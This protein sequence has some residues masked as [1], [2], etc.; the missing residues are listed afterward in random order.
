MEF[1]YYHFG[2]VGS[3]M[4]IIRPLLPKVEAN[5][6][7]DGRGVIVTA[8]FQRA[9]RGRIEGRSWSASPGSAMLA[10]IAIPHGAPQDAPQ[11]A[12][13]RSQ[14][15]PLLVGLAV[16]SVL[17]ETFGARLV[18]VRNAPTQTRIDRMPK[19]FLLKWP[20]DI[21]GLAPGT[22]MPLVTEPSGASRP[23]PGIP[24]YKKLA[25]ILC[26]AR[27]GWFLAGIGVN[28]REG[29]YPEELKNRATCLAEVVGQSSEAQDGAGQ[30]LGMN[31]L[32]S[33]DPAMDLS[34]Y[35][36]HRIADKIVEELENSSWKR[37]YE[38]NLWAKGVSVSFKVGHPDHGEVLNG[39]LEGI[40]E[41][42]CLVLALPNGKKRHF[43]AG[44]IAGLELSN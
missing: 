29:S 4:D 42:G 10:T 25:G 19:P 33:P 26:E 3:T 37:E 9:G 22:E 23:F 20:N 41:A 44:E 18:R 27:P 43:L 1:D 30:T 12:A 13:D 15:F 24:I 6:P 34:S 2:D 35:L 14:V 5:V 28:L 7:E 39:V 17:Y 11:D 38:Q 21:L 8:D 16:H 31:L 36:A 40:D 32:E